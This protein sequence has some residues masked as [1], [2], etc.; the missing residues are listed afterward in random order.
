MAILIP[1]YLQTGSY[2]AKKDRRVNS[3][4]VLQ[5]GIVQK[6]HFAV[7]QRGAGANLSVD[8][9]SGEAW[10]KGDSATDQGY[11][12]V[13][14][15]ATVNATIS[16]ANATNPRI[17]AVVLAVN[18]STEVGGS[19]S[20]LIEVIAGTPTAGATLANLK[21]VP[22]P[23][24][25][26][27]LLSYVLVAAAGTKV[28]NAAIGGLRDPHGFIPDWELA[29]SEPFAIAGAPAQYAHG[30]PLS[31]IPSAWGTRAVGFEVATGT[32]VAIPCTGTDA[33]DTEL[34]HSTGEFEGKRFVCKAPGTYLC[35]ANVMYTLGTLSLV[36]IRVNGI[37][38]LY[39]MEGS[40]QSL[41]TAGLFRLGYGDYVEGMTQQASGANK[42]FSGGVSMVWQ[43]P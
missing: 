33:W 15:D 4:M 21:G 32:P 13:V 38:S 37:S 7:S 41:N 2:S 11:Y 20:Y 9:S 30:R 24:A 8:V 31:W 12:H 19:D 36:W 23:G 14:N 1:N 43:A 17:D 5:E 39:Q 34:I 26:K 22:T 18:D 29:K 25:T 3:A 27:L 35:Q 28:E 42:V 6:G 40:N 10:V 16:A